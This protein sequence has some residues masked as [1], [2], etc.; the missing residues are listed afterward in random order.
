MS[1]NYPDDYPDNLMCSWTIEV[2]QDKQIQLEFLRFQ[3]GPDYHLMINDGE[4]CLSGF[5]VRI[6]EKP[7]EIFTS[8]KNILTTTLMSDDRGTD[9]GFKAFYRSDKYRSK[10]VDSCFGRR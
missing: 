4:D 6:F 2:E 10:Q 8:S 1:P 3:L 9:L 7:S 5:L